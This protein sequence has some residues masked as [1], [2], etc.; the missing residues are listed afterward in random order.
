MEIFNGRDA[1]RR[2]MMETVQEEL[3]KFGL[4]IYNANIKELEDAPNSKYFENMRQRK[5][6]DVENKA[7]TDIAE[8]KYRGDVGNSKNNF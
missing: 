2:R 8:A 7:R 5:L 4:I 6:A 3:K 1:F